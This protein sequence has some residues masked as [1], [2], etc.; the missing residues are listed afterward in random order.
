M[1]VVILCGGQGSRIRDV[2][3]V[4]PKP[5]LEIGGKPILWHIMK[6]YATHGL[7]DFILCLGYKGW[8]IK[9]FFLNYLPIISDCTI[10]LGS[11]QGI[12]FHDFIEEAPWRVT[13]ADTGEL[14]MTGN[15][16]WRVRKYLA[17]EEHFCL[18]YGDGVGDIDISALVDQHK[19]SGLVGTLTGVRVAGRFGE[20]ESREGKVVEFAEKPAATSGR[21]SG[22]FMVFDAK[23]VWDYLD[24]GDNL[25][26]EREPLSRMVSERQLGIY[27]HNGYWQCMDTLREYSQLNELWESEKAPWKI[28]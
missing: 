3:E 4:V 21:I 11:H 8:R 16:L 27:N 23:R 26:L 18:T 12:E 20:L 28:W 1:K 14:S 9:E 6:I 22:G 13:L 15:R 5:M 17:D 24:C 25:V 10:T 2:S 7:T 19:R